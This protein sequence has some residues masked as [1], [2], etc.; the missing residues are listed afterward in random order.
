MTHYHITPV[1]V[2][3]HDPNSCEHQFKSQVQIQPSQ[4][5]D[6]HVQ[7][8]LCSTKPWTDSKEWEK[9]VR[10]RGAGSRDFISNFFEILTTMARQPI[11]VGNKCVDFYKIMEVASFTVVIK[12]GTEG[13]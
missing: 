3:P 12:M 7:L 2:T 11:T 8:N 5:K 9:L 6:G 4:T 1:V 13:G 10:E